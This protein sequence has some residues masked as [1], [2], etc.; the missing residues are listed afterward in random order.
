MSA[1]PSDACTS[2]APPLAWPA[3]DDAAA[4]ARPV[5]S[6]EGACLPG[7]RPTAPADDGEGLPL[8][9][10]EYVVVDVETTGGS[11]RTGHRVTEI[12][13]LRVAHDGSILEEFTTLVNP[14]RPIPPFISALTNITWDMVRDAPRFHEI[15]AEV[16]RLLEGRIFVAHN[17]PFDWRFLS[18][19]LEHATGVA[20]QARV[21]CTVRLARKVVPEVASRSLDSLAYFFGLDNDARHRAFG[22]ARVTAALLGRLMRRLDDRGIASWEALQALLAQRTPRRSS[23]RRATPTSMDPSEIP[24]Q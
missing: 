18:W 10:L 17:A 9:A 22:D 21:L 12:A 20:P 19:E 14:E 8:S 3:A 2:V 1:H 13:A 23:R 4:D 11:T 16:G 6:P 7:S 5:D 15:A 24:A